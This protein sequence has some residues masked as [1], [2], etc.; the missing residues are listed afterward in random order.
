[1]YRPTVIRLGIVLGL[2]FFCSGLVLGQGVSARL[3]GVVKDQS[4]GII[5]GV[6]VVA[7]NQ[8]TN[9]PHEALSNETGRYVFPN[10][11]AGD[12]EITAELEGFKKVVQSGIILQ[13]GDARSL[14]LTLEAGDISQTVTVTGQA[15]LINSSD[16]KVGAV[17]GT[18]Q[19][20]GPASQWPQRHALGFSAGRNQPPGPTSHDF[21][22]HRTSPAERS[23]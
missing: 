4:G 21:H 11:P 23:G 13:I 8:D 16:T 2:L 20:V 15:S 14:D 3:E 19:A 5:P 1:M 9:L 22:G 18:E 10:L 12:Y 7:T 17:I 6:V